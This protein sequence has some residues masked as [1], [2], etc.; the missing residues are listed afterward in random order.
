MKNNKISQKATRSKTIY[1]AV[2]ILGFIVLI[3]LSEIIYSLKNRPDTLVNYYYLRI[4]KSLSNRDIGK[5]MLFYTKAAEIK[6][7]EVIKEHPDISVSNTLNRPALPN[8]PKLTGVYLD[9]LNS[10]DFDLLVGSYASQWAKHYYELGLIAYQ[11]NENAIAESY[12]LNAISLAPEWSYFHVELANY[13][14]VNN[15]PDESAM[16]IEHC[17][18]FDFPKDHC[19]E[20]DSDQGKTASPSP[21]GSWREKI[22]S[23]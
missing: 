14:L 20:Y 15:K 19:L 9:Y 13:Y 5:V 12:W 2:F 21:I 11:N 8:N 22:E 23:I 18:R 4:Q 1:A 7:L 17:I 6:L 10:I 3:L 16:V